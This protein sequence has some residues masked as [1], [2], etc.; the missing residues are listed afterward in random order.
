MQV[1][2]LCK[3][4]GGFLC[5]HI[6]IKVGHQPS[7]GHMICGLPWLGEGCYTHWAW[8]IFPGFTKN[9]V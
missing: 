3:H 8:W 1:T 9:I 5:N 2:P 6:L 7:L 4:T